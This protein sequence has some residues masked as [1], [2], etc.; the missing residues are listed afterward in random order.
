MRLRSF[1]DAVPL[2]GDEAELTV[3]QWLLAQRTLAVGTDAIRAGGGGFLDAL[4]RRTIQYI[5]AAGLAGVGLVPDALSAYGAFFHVAR[6][7]GETTCGRIN[8]EAASSEGASS[9]FDICYPGVMLKEATCSK[10]HPAL[11]R[12]ASK[13][14]ST[15]TSLQHRMRAR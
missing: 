7:V 11:R 2:R 10:K 14:I 12:P 5:Q 4:S 6:R 8:S 15:N 3:E 13:R 1:A 9:V